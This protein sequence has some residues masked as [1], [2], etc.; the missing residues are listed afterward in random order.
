LLPIIT[1]ILSEVVSNANKFTSLL[2]K[3]MCRYC[4]NNNDNNNK[5][6][7]YIAIA[8]EALAVA[9]QTR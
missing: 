6:P 9:K 3:I 8:S 7:V 2:N 1:A 5:Q 4:V